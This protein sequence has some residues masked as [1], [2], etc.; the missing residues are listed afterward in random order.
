MP[1]KAIGPTTADFSKLQKRVWKG[2]IEI[3]KVEGKYVP[4]IQVIESDPVTE[5]LVGDCI[6]KAIEEL[7][8]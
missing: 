1:G 4:R 5:K 7:R 2:E 6:K 8:G 3:Y